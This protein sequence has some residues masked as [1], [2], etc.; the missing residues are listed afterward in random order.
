MALTRIASIRRFTSHLP[1]SS[2]T[3]LA[4]QA[5]RNAR[6]STVIQIDVYRFL[7]TL[8]NSLP[9]VFGVVRLDRSY[10][11]RHTTFPLKP[12]KQLEEHFSKLSFRLC[13]KRP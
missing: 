1:S 9:R 7:V 13:F 6:F 8:D 3:P 12:T 11:A 5:L 10:L 2:S 4:Y